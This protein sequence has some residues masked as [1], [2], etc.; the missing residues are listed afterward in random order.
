MNAPPGLGVR[1]ILR[2]DPQQVLPGVT[3]RAV[4]GHQEVVT[5][6][7]VKPGRDLSHF[8]FAVHLV[9]QL[10]PRDVAFVLPFHTLALEIPKKNRGCYYC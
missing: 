2:Q 8:R 9:N 5:G 3:L 6:V 4:E 1:T 7:K 10:E